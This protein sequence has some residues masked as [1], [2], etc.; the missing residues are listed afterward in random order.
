MQFLV[1]IPNAGAVRG[2]GV[3]IY[4]DSACKHRA[5]SIVWGT[6]DP[7]SSKIVTVYVKNIG[8]AAATLTKTVSNW[9]PI[10]AANYLA[11]T[12]TYANQ[13]I[14]VNNVLQVNLTLSIPSTVTAITNFNFNLVITASG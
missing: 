12:W 9:V 14:G 2:V 4:W 11:V 6:I 8:N 1:T 5:T 10:T 7:G 13:I 3:G